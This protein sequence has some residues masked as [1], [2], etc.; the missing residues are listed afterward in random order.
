VE[1]LENSGHMGM[2][3]EKEAVNKF[4]VDFITFCTNIRR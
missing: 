3:E 4:L 1:I 2:V